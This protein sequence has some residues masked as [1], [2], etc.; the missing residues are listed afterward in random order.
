[1]ARPDDTDAAFEAAAPGKVG[2]LFGLDTPPSEALVWVTALPFDATASG[3]RGTAAAPAAILEASADVDLFDLAFGPAWEA[4]LAWL[5]AP[6]NLEELN[7]EAGEL[8][9]ELRAG[10]GGASARRRVDAIGAHVA[11]LAEV[12]VRD[13]HRACRIPAIVGGDHSV[14]LGAMAAAADL[15]EDGLGVLH[16]DAHAD[17]RAVYEGFRFSHAS[18]FHEL[19]RRT[20]A[21]AALVQVGLRDVGRREWEQVEA[22]PGVHAWPDHVLGARLAAGDLLEEIVDDILAPLP[23]DVWISLDV[24]GLDPSLC[25]HTGTPVPGGL[26]WRDVDY[27]LQRLVDDHHRIVG[28]D[29]VEVAPEP[30]DAAVGARLLFKLCGAAVRCSPDSLAARFVGR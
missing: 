27:L 3:R 17:M 28:F 25:P 2:L 6:D 15:V 29:L 8:V 12:A 13:A 16:I 10:S 21:P 30:W 1:M 24:D 4:G 20:P 14:S 22:H 9:R 7:A 23:R 5:G 26:G 18:V 19:M 11:S